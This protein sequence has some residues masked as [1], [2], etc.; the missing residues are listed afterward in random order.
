MH[1]QGLD[2]RGS[3]GPSTSPSRWT[4]DVLATLAFFDLRHWGISQ[5]ESYPKGK[6]GLLCPPGSCSNSCLWVQHSLFF[7]SNNVTVVGISED[8]HCSVCWH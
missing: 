2:P 6:L 3:G 5:E 4:L 7:S 1:V 8:N